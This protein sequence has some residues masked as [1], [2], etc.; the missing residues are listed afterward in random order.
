MYQDSLA[1]ILDE[2][3]RVDARLRM[4]VWQARQGDTHSTRYA[5]FYLSDA[6]VDALLAKPPGTPGWVAPA[7]PVASD[8]VEA[9]LA[10]M[11]H[12]IEDRKRH[13]RGVELRLVELARLAGLSDFEVD[14]ILVALAPE[15]DLRYGH[16]YAYLQDDATRKR[17]T[18]DLTLHLLCKTLAEKVAAR[19][20]FTAGSPL[21]HHQIIHLPQPDRPLL[22]RDIRLDERIVAY[23]LG[24]D[25]IDSRLQPYVQYVTPAADL[26]DLVLSPVL[27]AKLAHVVENEP[28][29]FYFQGDYGVGKQTAAEALCRRLRTGL[30]VVDGAAQRCYTRMTRSPPASGA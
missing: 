20:A 22:E 3:Q 11:E 6:D 16:L 2:L 26:D 7:Q 18:V 23:L 14:V 24:S 17:P 21:L 8:E 15:I 13:S 12:Q 9:A 1:H 28:M 10:Q 27:R 30:L 25:E 5:G 19:Q 29:A 4:A